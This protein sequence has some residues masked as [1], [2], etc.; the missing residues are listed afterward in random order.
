MKDR[1]IEPRFL[2]AELVQVEWA[3]RTEVVNLDDI[4]ISGACL[5]SSSRI[6]AGS[7]VLM[8][9]TE[10]QLP[11]IVRYCAPFAE[12][13]LVGLQFTFGCKWSS[14]FFEPAHLLDIRPGYFPTHDRRTQLQQAANRTL[15]DQQARSY[16]LE[17]LRR[18]YALQPCKSPQLRF[19]RLPQI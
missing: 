5:L 14:D 8:T 6:P 15:A 16:G 7:A 9:Y 1:R 2:C 3:A 12:D 10:G 4:S 18:L 19:D 13:Y 17:L 11:G